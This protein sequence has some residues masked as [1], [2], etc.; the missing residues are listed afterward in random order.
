MKASSAYVQ[1]AGF[2]VCEFEHY[3]DK[4][5]GTRTVCEHYLD[6]DY[7]LSIA[8]VAIVVIHLFAAFSSKAIRLFH[9]FHT[10][11]SVRHTLVYKHLRIQL[12]RLPRGTQSH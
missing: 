2:G 6:K 10:R 8:I 5:S 3:A 1:Q 7:V 12:E 4:G 9:L 11:T